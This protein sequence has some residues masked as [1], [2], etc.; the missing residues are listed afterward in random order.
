MHKLKRW[1]PVLAIAPL[2]LLAGCGPEEDDDEAADANNGG[3]PVATAPDT[4]ATGTASS[5]AAGADAEKNADTAAERIE[6]LLEADATLKS[7]DLEADEE[8][9]RVVLK[10]EVKTPEQKTLAENIARENAGGQ[11]IDSK[12]T[13]DAD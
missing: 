6:D 10:G 1:I 5:P 12:I 7:F 9:N 13:V 11:T 8:D 2:L 4:M 3:A